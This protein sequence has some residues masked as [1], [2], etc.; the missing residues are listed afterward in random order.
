MIEF[1]TREGTWISVDV[2][3]DGSTLVFD[4]L[5]DLYLL[6]IGGG[7]AR[8]IT[9]GLAF[10]TQPAFSP[11][12]AEILFV[13]DVSGAENFWVMSSDGSASRQVSSNVDVR[14]FASPAWSAD[15]RTVFGSVFRPDLGAYELWSFDAAGGQPGERLVPVKTEPDQP[16]DT[17]VSSLGAAASADG[18]F[19]YFAQHRGGL[20]AEIPAWTVQRLD[21][22][23]GTIEPVIQPA[24]RRRRDG[25]AG[26]YFRPVPS[27]EGR[28]LVYATRD[29]ARTVLRLRDLETGRD[30]RLVGPVQRDQLQA[31]TSVQDLLPRYAFTADGKSLIY[32]EDNGLRRLHLDDGRIE[33][34]PFRAAISVGLGPDLRIDIEQET[35]PVRARL[36]QTPVVSPDGLRLAFS[37]LGRIYLQSLLDESEPE[38]LVELPLGQFHPSW[39]PDGSRIAFVT[40]SGS[41]AGQVWVASMD[42][43]SP[44]RRVTERADLYEWPAFTPDGRALLVQRSRH[45]DR[46]H[47]YLEF[48]ALREAELI[49]VDLADGSV[50]S[51]AA[52]EM[53]GRPQPLAGGREVA[54][55]LSGEL[56]AVDLATGERRRLVAARG[57]GWYF[58]EGPARI[59][60]LAISPDGSQVLARDLAQQLYLFPMPAVSGDAGA[61]DALGTVD[62]TDPATV[63]QQVTRTGADFFGWADDGRTITWALGSTWYRCALQPLRN[64]RSSLE[65]NEAPL[66]ELGCLEPEAFGIRVEVPRDRP[67]GD[68]VLRG[69]TVITMAGDEVIVNADLHVAGDRIVAIG[70][71]G[72]VPIPNGARVLSAEGAFIVPGFTDTHDHLADIRRGM[73]DL[74]SWGAAANLAYGVTTAF[75]PSPLSIDMLVYEDLVDAGMIVGSRIHSTGPAIF[76][77]HDFRS[78]DEVG[79]VLL[80]YR[81]HYRTRNLKMYR[82]GNR[83]VRQWVA[84]K[85]H[86]LGLMPTTEGALAMKL[87]LTQVLDGFAGHEHELVAQPL[88]RDVVELMARSGVAYSPTLIISAGPDAEQYFIARDDPA[89]DPKLARFWPSHVIDLKLRHASWHT[90]EEYSFPG[91]AADAAKILRAG[92]TIGVGSH[93]N[94][95][96]VGFHWEMQALAMGGMT[97]AEVLR[98][99]TLLSARAIGRGD[100]FGSLEPGKYADLVVLDRDPRADIANTLSIRRVMKNGRLYD[101]DTLDEIWP[102]RRAFPRPQSAEEP[103]E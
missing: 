18:R 21:L 14:M 75:D 79:E 68:V 92:G 20:D 72:R 83:R 74:A 4:L 10:D 8:A 58:A 93:G 22:A 16:R 55:N 1:E 42:R 103:S 81:D 63:H 99:A 67:V 90:F 17:W 54:I 32:S 26:S 47:R 43:G 2:S 82:T 51:L 40:W 28:A 87:G 89:N 34:I 13:S 24:E 100:E 96:G 101:G 86:E 69:A 84:M 56:A 11:D 88:G 66:P 38:P 5:G 15:G 97:P 6:D 45:V 37:A 25:P 41:D 27:P 31:L 19:L 64:G 98:A 44:P 78:E 59:E 52:G 80:R 46:M 35:G 61:E 7:Q 77:F 23:S 30:R 29:R 62:L 49:R 76:S 73:V 65:R 71:R 53:G 9:R 50:G 57:H 102:R 36:I 70:P 60:E 85:A 3:P 95:P 12:G 91:A 39:S 48:G 33:E 94:A